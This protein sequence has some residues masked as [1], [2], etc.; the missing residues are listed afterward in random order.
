MI[1]YTDLR[2]NNMQD[3]DK[4]VNKLSVP[5]EIREIMDEKVSKDEMQ[6][7]KNSLDINNEKSTE[8]ENETLIGFILEKM[9]ELGIPDE[10][11]A[12]Y[13]EDCKNSTYETLMVKAKKI[14]EYYAEL[15]HK[16]II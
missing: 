16:G 6:R 13:K 12:Q 8:M 15:K 11:I 10:N 4:T 3:T 1:Y 7:Q 14:E 9:G 2:R 5:E